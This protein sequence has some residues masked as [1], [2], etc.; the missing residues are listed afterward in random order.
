MD[1]REERIGKNETLFREVNE[2]IEE[3]AEGERTDFLC[4]CGDIDCAQTITLTLSEYEALR[5]EPDRFAVLPGHEQLDV[6]E[7]VER[8]EGY[9][10]VRKHAGGPAELAE[11]ADPRT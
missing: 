11:A 4:E 9:V 1:A 7:V 8:H 6:E 10:V 2:R 3:I 5:A